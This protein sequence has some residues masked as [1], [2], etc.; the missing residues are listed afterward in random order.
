MKAIILA[1]G[2]GVRLKP[3]TEDKP[4]CLLIVGGK[5]LIKRIVENLYRENIVDISIVMGYK[6]E[7]VINDLKDYKINYI[8]NKNYTKGNALSLFLA[9]DKLNDEVLILDGDVLFHQ[10]ILKILINSKHK[11]CVLIDQKFKDTG[12]EMKIIV[13]KGRVDKIGRS[14]HKSCDLFGEGVGIVKLSKQAA[15]KLKDYL[16]SLYSQGLIDKDYEDVL[17]YVFKDFNFGYEQIRDLPWIE[18]DFVDDYNKAKKY[19]LPN[20]LAMQEKKI[21]TLQCLL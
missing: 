2:I 6:K 3:L 18:I 15:L 19:I 4:K 11:N 21:L 1:A 13:N 7:M 12:E 17:N 16:E 10:D 9:K 14:V 20:I 8:V 5:S